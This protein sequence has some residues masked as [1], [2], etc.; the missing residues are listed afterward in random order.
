MQHPSGI[1]DGPLALG[2]RGPW[3]AA[4]PWV[5]ESAPGVRPRTV[6]ASHEPQPI[7]FSARPVRPL[8]MQLRTTLIAASALLG[9]TA[10]QAVAQTT[11]GS[12][13]PGASGVTPTVSVGGT[14]TTGQPW[15]LD[16][17]SPGG[18]GLEYILVGSSNTSASVL[19]GLPLPFDLGLV[20][21]DPAWSG[22]PLNVDADILILARNFNPAVNG[23][24]HKIP[25]PGYSFGSLY[26]QVLNID[27]NFLTFSPIAGVSQG[28]EV[29]GTV[30]TADL[31]IT[32]IMKNPST[33]GDSSGEYF[34]VFNTTGSAIDIEG[35]TLRDD[36][37][38]SMVLDNGGAGIIVPGSS[39]FV[40]GV[41][42]DINTNGGVPV[43]FEWNG[44]MFLSN[45]ADEIVLEDDLGTEVCRV[46]YDDGVTFPDTNGAA[47]E[48]KTGFLN[49]VD[50][51]NGA[52]WEDADCPLTPSNNDFGTPG[53]DNDSCS[54]VINNGSGELIVV[55]VMKDSAVIADDFGEYFE[56]Y[57]TTGSAIDM[58][59]YTITCGLTF[60]VSGSFV[61]PAGGYG[62]F[63]REDDPTFNGGI[64]PLAVNA[65]D[66]MNGFFL[67]QSGGTIVIEDASSN[68]ITNFSYDNGVTFPDTTGVSIILDPTVT[69]DNAASLDGTNWCVSS[70]TYTG[71]GFLDSAATTPVT[72]ITQRGTPG[73]ANDTCPI[74]PFGTA[75]GDLIVTEVMSNPT[76]DNDTPFEWFEIYNTTGSAIDIDGY[77]LADAGSDYHVINNGGALLVPAGGR[78]V[79]AQ[80]S[81]APSGAGFASDYVYGATNFFGG[82]IDTII[83]A[84]GSGQKV[85]ELAYDG[86][87][88]W[89][90]PNGGHSMI[91]D[92]S[93]ALNAASAADPANWCLSF[94]TSYDADNFGTPGGV[95]DVCPIVPSG[96]ATGDLVITEF[97]NDGVGAEN[98]EF[99]EVYNTT[100]SAI[101]LNG[102]II[103][104]AGS[105]YHIVSGSVIVPA[106]GYA[107]L[108]RT[109][110]TLI[111]GGVTH[112][113]AWGAFDFF[114]SN[115]TDEIIVADASGQIVAD[116][117]FDDGISF[118]E[119]AECNSIQLDPA[120]AITQANSV[121]GANWCYSTTGFGD[122]TCTGS[123][124][125]ANEACGIIVPPG[126][127]AANPGD[128]IVTEFM[129]NPSAVFDNVGEWFE[130][131]NT[132][133]A[134]IN[135]EGWTFTDNGSNTFT[136]ASQVDVPAGSYVVLANNA[137]T[138]TN[139]GITVVDYEFPSSYALGNGSDAIIISDIN[140]TEISRVEWDDGATYPDGN[141]A[142]AQLDSAAGL[143]AAAVLVGSNWSLS[144]AP[145]GSGD[146]GTPGS[147]N[148]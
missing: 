66:T 24:L 128:I 138:L 47:M 2:E 19:G 35:W 45:G 140:L 75:T 110:D 76:P 130:I 36:G 114:L 91:L 55:E 132:T 129:Q 25:F 101:D 12:G 64:D 56:V 102:Y 40:I 99:F 14:V 69:Q 131:Y 63:L 8:N 82:F 137:D 37:S 86:G 39:Y 50:N 1:I 126:G 134:T 133:G 89:P 67:A 104:D 127:D 23:G 78:L 60:T 135:I 32:E 62:V 53:G 3:T 79:L 98:E 136:V 145:Y 103:G 30:P 80:G 26:F 111:N 44:T 43:D 100:G 38:D 119:S 10:T 58:N 109:N 83:L 108:G 120:V 46:N 11:F 4:L 74:T 13:C 61:I 34:E 97:L 85:A 52:N 146:L 41:N 73:T 141:G 29:I 5:A 121:N 93:A 94:F 27:P 57:N 96:S 28:I 144:T 7:G 125:A 51:D 72:N 117:T 68:V 21:G 118:P 16:I 70:S 59:G 84:D 48:L 139:G 123:P 77:I 90:V 148:N 42:G 106:G 54:T 88:G 22:C 95:N 116:I 9:A 65:Y 15:T 33:V 6:E 81:T 147:A 49:E 113:Y 124:A 122:L 17:T 71:D 143:T 107:S 105:D 112:D 92:P 87:A 31:V 142:S 115:G 20:F 18:I